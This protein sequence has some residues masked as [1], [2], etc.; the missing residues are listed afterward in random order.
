MQKKK[1]QL[2]IASILM[3]LGMEEEVIETITGLTKKE[4]YNK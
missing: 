3:D 4:L 2:F 1:S